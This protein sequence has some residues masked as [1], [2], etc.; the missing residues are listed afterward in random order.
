MFP[1][2]GIFFMDIFMSFYI[3][4]MDMVLLEMAVMFAVWTVFMIIIKGRLRKTVGVV[5]TV[6]ALLMILT[7]TV[8]RRS[9]S[10]NLLNLI[11][12]YT[13][14]AAKIQ[15]ELYRT[16]A[17]NLFMFVPFGM[18]FPFS[19]PEKMRFKLLVTV[20]FALVFSSA[21]EISQYVFNLGMCDIDDLIFNALGALLGYASFGICMR[22]DAF[23]KRHNE[24]RGVK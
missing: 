5:F 7:I 6:L 11:P 3:Q 22:A 19:L 18:S 12:F 15:P 9:A 17:M 23:V 21:I 14:E 16:L 24:K 2:N 13:F 4:P 10:G 20:L 8:F 1:R